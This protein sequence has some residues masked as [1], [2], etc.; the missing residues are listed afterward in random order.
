[1]AFYSKLPFAMLFALEEE[2]S[3]VFS[4]KKGDWIVGVELL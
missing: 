2:G 1:M 4:F 3:G